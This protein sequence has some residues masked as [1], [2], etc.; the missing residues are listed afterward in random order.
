MGQQIT[1]AIKY[2]AQFSCISGISHALM[3]AAWNLTHSGSPIFP[4]AI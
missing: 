3:L 4:S 1:T 2:N